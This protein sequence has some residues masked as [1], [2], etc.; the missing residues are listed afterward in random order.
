[1]ENLMELL[2]GRRTYRRFDESKKIS[3]K[4]VEKMQCATRLASSA[5]NRQPL[6]YIYVRDTD[7]VNAIFDITSWGGSLPNGL[8]R[9]KE[10]E[11]PAM[12]V[13]VLSVRELQT[14]FTDFDAGLAVSNMTLAAFE[15]GVGSCILGSVKIDALRDLLNIP[16]DVD[17][18][19]AVG[20]GYPTHQSTIVDMVDGD[21]RYYLD[22]NKDYLVPKRKNEDVNT[23][24]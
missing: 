19:T 16:Q 4:T 3:D 17:V 10:G 2:E 5:M 7:T 15:D 13:V 1:M 18:V 6:R 9:P 14:R 12:F 8:G 22:Q 23:E 20:F 21:A 24:I 11:R